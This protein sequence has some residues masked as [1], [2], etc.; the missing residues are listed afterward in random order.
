MNVL[1]QVVKENTQ[2]TTAILAKSQK[3]SRTK[4]F[5]IQYFHHHF[6]AC[7]HTVTVTGI[8]GIVREMMNFTTILSIWQKNCIE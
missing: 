4:V 8:W 7:I 3:K 1:D 6:L 5:I 2:Y